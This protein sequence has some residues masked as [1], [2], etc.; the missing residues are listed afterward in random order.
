[1]TSFF[2]DINVWL[3]LS[4]FGHEHNRDAWAWMGRIPSDSKL[5][6]SRFTQIGLLRLLA[7]QPVMG[8]A[9]LTLGQA[10]I[11]Y[12]KWLGDPRVEFYPEPRDV[13]IA[14]RRATSPFAAQRA[15]KAVGDC[16][17]LAFAMEIN[18]TLV[19][20]DRALFELCRKQG[21]T[22]VIPA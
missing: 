7:S 10:W 18:A 21:H 2:P 15:S 8:D 6:L 1:M 22:A 5:V 14:F 4:D 11:V 17:L 19:T 3:A 12:D 9:V 13:D 16:W 20:F